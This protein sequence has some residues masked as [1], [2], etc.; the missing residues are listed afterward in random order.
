MN[1]LKLLDNNEQTLSPNSFVTTHINVKAPITT[2]PKTAYTVGVSAEVQ[3]P[4]DMIS[5]FKQDVSLPAT[6]SFL[7]EESPVIVSTSFS[8]TILSLWDLMWSSFERVE[9][10][11]GM[12]S[13]VVAI[14][15][16]IYKL[17]RK[18]NSQQQLN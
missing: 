1:G 13:T 10:I 3:K 8:V 2:V 12:V 4:P 16:A 18:T 5:E 15:T 6:V 9:V 7:Y 17:K 14:F 11:L